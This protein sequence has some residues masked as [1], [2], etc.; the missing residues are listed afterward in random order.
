MSTE[1]K[2]VNK[3]FNK[4]YL[5]CKDDDA[6]RITIQN[7]PTKKSKILEAGSGSGR[8]VKYLYD[9]GYKNTEGIELNKEAIRHFNKKYPYIKNIQGD[10]LN[11]PYRANSFD[12]IATY[13]V[14]EH[15]LPG[16]EQPLIALK[17][18]LKK[19]GLLIVTVPSLNYI[20]YVVYIKD[21]I[22][23]SLHFWGKIN[24]NKGVYYVH[25]QF[26]EFFEYR[27][28]PNEFRIGCINAGYKI[29]SE[30]PIYH[31]DGLYH[32][33]GNKLVKYI[34]Y[35]FYPNIIG[36]ILN[37]F[38]TAVPYAHNHMHLIVLKKS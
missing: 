30:Q 10:I 21:M 29:V 2:W 28:T 6:V 11:M 7:I 34:N 33:F 9:L 24:R 14:V 23:D 16:I 8:V 20:R 37:N 17:K 35:I 36:T 1:F 22:K 25:P 18:I 15:F 3:D 27:L 13:G 26:G 4:M 12:V 32:T 19:N 38:L 5:T 31:M